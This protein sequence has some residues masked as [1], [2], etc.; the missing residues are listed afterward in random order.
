M[1][2]RPGKHPGPLRYAG[3]PETRGGFR[4]YLMEFIDWMGAMHFSFNIPTMLRI[5]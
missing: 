5:A 2:G 4:A 1:S 3:D